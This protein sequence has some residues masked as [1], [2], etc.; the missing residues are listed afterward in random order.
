MSDDMRHCSI[1]KHTLEVF[2]SIDELPMARFH[3]YNKMLLIDS[4]IGSDMADIDGHIER[5]IAYM[6]SGN[7]A[8]AVGELKNLRN[9]IYFIHENV[10]PRHL[11]FAALV[12]SIDGVPYDDLTD[13][14]L[15]R[16]RDMLQDATVEDMTALA[17]AVKKKIDTEMSMYFPKLYEDATVKEYYDELRRRTLM[18]LENIIAGH[19]EQ[20]AQDID[21]T[22]VRLYLFNPPRDFEGAASLEV[23]YDRQFDDM[24]FLMSQHVNCDPRTYTVREY[25]NVFQRIKAMLKKKSK[26]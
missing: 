13:E 1:G 7:T 8:E 16:V 10:S 18:V 11:A 22:T 20:R 21:A 2:D 26:R 4:G 5:A 19:D 3:R 14:G 23:E 12:K 25:Y 9:N 6:N 15:Q 17:G 24:C